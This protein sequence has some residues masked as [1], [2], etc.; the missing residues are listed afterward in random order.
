[1]HRSTVLISNGLFRSSVEAEL[2]T[3]ADL[4]LSTDADEASRH[5]IYDAAISLAMCIG[6]RKAITRSALISAE[7]RRSSAVCARMVENAKSL[8]RPRLTIAENPFI[9]RPSGGYL[10]SRQN[11]MESP[12]PRIAGRGCSFVLSFVSRR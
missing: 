8:R 3:V 4:T 7:H 9:V 12:R 10:F 6:Y 1:L 2:Y 11:D 5:S